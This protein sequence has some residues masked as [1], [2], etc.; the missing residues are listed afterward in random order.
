MIATKPDRMKVKK[1]K[2]YINDFGYSED[3]LAL[4]RE[5]LSEDEMTLF[6]EGSELSCECGC[7]QMVALSKKSLTWEGI[8]TDK[9]NRFIFGHHSRTGKSADNLT[10]GRAKMAKRGYGRPPGQ[11]PANKLSPPMGDSFGRVT[12]LGDFP[13]ASGRTEWLFECKCGEVFHTKA[14]RVLNGETKSCG[15]LVGDARRQVAAQK[16]STASI[17]CQVCNKPRKP[18][19]SNVY[20]E[21]H[22]REYKRRGYRKRL[23]GGRS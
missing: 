10:Q 8:R 21:E 15:C 9:P 4:I 23:P 19:V 17:T 11:P 6:L 18:G 13:N 5:D 14:S 3:L 22:L 1:W 7:G 16:A 20:C 12:V 2:R